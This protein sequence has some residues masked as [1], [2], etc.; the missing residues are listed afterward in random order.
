ML[1]V[2]L[3]LPVKHRADFSNKSQRYIS[4]QAVVII[5]NFKI[6]T[7][8]QQNVSIQM[9]PENMTQVLLLHS[10]EIATAGW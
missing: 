9:E 4:F 1:T 2:S 7:I 5:K 8:K 10:L 3:F 6:S